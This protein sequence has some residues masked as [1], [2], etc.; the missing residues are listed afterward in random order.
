V[1]KDTTTE[2]YWVQ[3]SSKVIKRKRKHLFPLTNT[4]FKNSTVSEDDRRARL[5]EIA[6]VVIV[7]AVIVTVIMVTVAVVAAVV[8]RNVV[9]PICHIA[10]KLYNGVYVYRIGNSMCDSGVPPLILEARYLA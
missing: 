10:K 3:V 5:I 9:I 7:T 6:T 2:S 1:K 4:S 8:I